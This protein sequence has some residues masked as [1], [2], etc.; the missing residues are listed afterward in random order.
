MRKE[1]QG[2]LWYFSDTNEKTIVIFI[3]KT[4]KNCK[5]NHA[6][7]QR[8]FFSYFIDLIHR[9]FSLLNNFFANLSPGGF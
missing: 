5:E 2:F 4:I 8:F 1:L 9:S 3:D 6:K 7:V